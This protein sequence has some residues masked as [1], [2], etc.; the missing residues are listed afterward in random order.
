MVGRSDPRAMLQE[1][2]G[3]STMGTRSRRLRDGLVI[4]EVALALVLAVGRS[5]PDSRAG[6][7]AATPIPDS[8][9]RTS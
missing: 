8:S 6:S 1:S 7:P 5:G 2:G 9:R 4:A 3:H